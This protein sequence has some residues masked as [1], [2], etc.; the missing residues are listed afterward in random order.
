MATAAGR[1]ITQNS[2]LSHASRRPLSAR[3]PISSATPVSAAATMTPR[4]SSTGL[5]RDNRDRHPAAW[6]AGGAARR[7]LDFRGHIEQ[8]EQ[9]CDGGCV[10]PAQRVR[11]GLADV[12]ENT[13]AEVERRGALA[14]L[15][16]E[17][18]AA[19]AALDE[20]VG[21]AEDEPRAQSGGCPLQQL[22][23]DSAHRLDSP[24][25]GV[26]PRAGGDPRVRLAF[27][28]QK[29]QHGI[30]RRQA[31]GAV[32][33]ALS[34][35]PA[36][37]EAEPRRQNVGDALMEAGDQDASDTRVTHKEVGIGLS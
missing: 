17:A 8:L 37:V 16:R 19:E 25:G 35:E 4:L 34:V 13:G 5:C 26:L 10:E 29:A 6:A 7:H 33:Q 21:Q 31:D 11:H 27:L 9:P 18:A 1:P 36:L 24:L 22:A 14:Q 12:A 20:P 3:M 2:E 15:E 23:L 30:Q 32:T 28:P